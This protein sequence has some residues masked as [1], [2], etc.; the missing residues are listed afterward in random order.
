MD[1]RILLIAASLLPLAGCSTTKPSGGQDAEAKRKELDA[2]TDRALEN[3][4]KQVPSARQI[5]SQSKGVLIFPNVISA[6][7]GIGGSYGDGELRKGG[8]V[9]GYYTL[10]GGSIGLIAGAQSKAMYVAFM[11]DEALSKFETSKG[12]TAGVDANVAAGT[13]GA[14]IQATTQTVQR[15]VVG[16][17]L[18]NAGLMA[19]ATFDGTK[20]TKK[21]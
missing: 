21:S 12:W 13:M 17:V 15:P 16:Y 19:N 7:L 11:T 8:A 3:L 14:D 18:T 9:A 6:G 2:D 1:R 5:V 10:A 20:I 4:Y